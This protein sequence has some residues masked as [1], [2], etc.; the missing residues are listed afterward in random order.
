MPSTSPG[1]VSTTPTPFVQLLPGAPTSSLQ[2][3]DSFIFRH[4]RYIAY[5]S[6]R[7]LNL[8][9]SPTTLVQALTF[10]EDLVALAAEPGTG[11]IAV[12]SK[13][14]IWV[15]E[16]LT[17]GWTK[18]WWE[19]T[20]FLVHED[21][22][23]EAHCL[24]WGNEG[25][26]LIGG[27]R[28]LSLFSTL[29]SSRTSA[30]EDGDS[31]EERRTL[32]SKDVASPVWHAAFSPGANLISTCGRYDRL[33]KIW[34]RLSFEEGL[35]DYTYLPHPGS[36]THL[37][38]RP[39]DENSEERRESGVSGRYEDEPE[40]LYTLANDGLLRIWRSGGAHDLDI[41]LLYTSVDLGSAIPQSPSLK[42]KGALHS[43]AARYTFILPSSRFNAAVASAIGL[44]AGQLSHS[45][46]HL[47]EV[48]SKDPDVIITL[49]GHGRMSAWGLQ[50]IGHKRRPDTPSGYSKQAFHI[51]HTEGLPLRVAEGVNARFHAWFEDS[52]FNILVHSFGGYVQWW[53]G[54]VETFFSPSAAGPERLE[55]S[56]Y[57]S[58]HLDGPIELLKGSNRTQCLVSCSS[59]RE[60][61]TWAPGGHV[62]LHNRAVCGADGQVLDL[63]V[64]PSIGGTDVDAIVLEQS[65]SDPCKLRVVLRDSR[66]RELDAKPYD[67]ELGDDSAKW[68]IYQSEIF[69]AGATVEQRLVAL[70]SNGRGITF[71]TT[72]AQSKNVILGDLMSISLPAPASEDSYVHAAA[73]LDSSDVEKIGIVCITR[74]GS[75]LL[76]HLQLLENVDPGYPT[77]MA[78]F[79]SGIENASLMGVSN[80]FAA[81]VSSNRKEFAVVNLRDGYIEH[82]HSAKGHIH[83]IVLSSDRNGLFAVG[84]DDSV[85]ILT[86]GRYGYQDDTPPWV[87]VKHISIAAIG[88]T[89]GVM[90]W[91]GDGSLALA[92]GNGVLVS[93]NDVP[94]AEVERDLQEAIRTDSNAGEVMRLS[95]LSD[96]LKAP[97][98]VWHPSVLSFIVQHGH[99]VLATVLISKLSHKLKFWSEG[100]QLDA[101]L[102]IPATQF[103][104]PD[105]P[106]EGGLLD[107]GL[108][109]DLKLQLEERDLP[110]VSRKEQQ[111]LKRAVQAIGHCAEHVKS[112]DK[113]ALRFLFSWR[114]AL[115]HMDAE[116]L[117]N[118][119]HNGVPSKASPAIPEMHW[120][121]IAFAYHSTTQQ[122]LLDILTAH[123]DNK[124]TWNI[125]RRLGLL[126]WLCDRQAL[127]QI[128]EAL[129]QST[130]RATSPPD[131]INASLYFLALHKKPTLIALWRIATWHKEQRATMNF[132]R[133]DFTLQEHKTAAKKNAYAL[134]GKKRFDYAA[135]FF[136]LAE[137]PA[138]ATSVLASQ[139]ED[140]MLAIA[141][142]RLHGGDGSPVLRRLLEDRLMPNAMQTGNR[143]LMSWCHSILLE[144]D[145]AADAL[146][147]PLQ[148]VRNWQ[149]DAPD[150]L[151]LYGQLRKEESEFEYDAV[152]RAAR[153]LRRLG[154]WLSALELVSG[155][156]FR[157]P[158]AGAA[159]ARQPAAEVTTNG[160]HKDQQQVASMLDGFSDT[161]TALAHREPPSMLDEFATPQPVRTP[162]EDANAAREAKAAEMLKK[163]KAKKEG[164]PP[165]QLDEKVKP[166]PTQFKEPDANSLLDNF[167]F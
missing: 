73:V 143:W 11:K 25:E 5:I 12:A 152:L 19:K 90:A 95:H 52:R 24:S 26:V 72:L 148:G 65:P 103:Y 118:G 122:S 84:Y 115:L 78:T 161:G 43:K 135:A 55:A 145:R 120:R 49:D 39:L 100:D 140:V 112:L 97:L 155:W 136:L 80:E 101:L 38:W 6:G 149:Q 165:A 76:Y 163:L 23:D 124:V 41:L 81:I 40:V 10:N 106:A 42:M 56:A 125:A 157:R 54:A 14:E 110:M 31:V 75:V 69:P 141:V 158:T 116:P 4:K 60:V 93:S 86:Q 166:E 153:I 127:E 2:S 156:E 104:G 30:P 1:H 16:P 88:L 123:Y 96:H 146:V 131:P 22:G 51:A 91:L 15:L 18:V 20:L 94:I 48:S 17:E 21:P 53:R 46:E 82:W 92:A 105:R 114:L 34:R 138:S 130:Y 3:L 85:D 29:P 150:T 134:M 59:D 99:W 50:S 109:S 119:Q 67:L 107:E 154:L 121:E 37:E 79:E 64:I 132:L 28:Q 9:S 32:W 71:K 27:S 167:G 47:K 159:Q 89:V 58:G 128:F 45:L 33:V 142:G 77:L 111:R 13:R 151:T 63:T 36:V 126:A 74:A 61:A 162:S 117:P 160:I 7:Q 62:G 70:N 108:I 8:L 68:T 102:D 113:G 164:Q 87:L 44:Q 98:P 133:R 83:H 35:F 137:D 66:G 129:A 57:W 144:P 139:C 147:A